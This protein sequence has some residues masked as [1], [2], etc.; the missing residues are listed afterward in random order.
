MLRGCVAASRQ[1]AGRPHALAARRAPPLQLVPP[2]SSLSL[3]QHD[4]GYTHVK[5]TRFQSIRR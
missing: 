2:P 4:R 1:L 5:G 3:L